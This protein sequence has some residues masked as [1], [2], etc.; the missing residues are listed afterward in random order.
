MDKILRV[1]EV[2]NFFPSGI[3][4]DYTEIKDIWINIDFIVSFEKASCGSLLVLTSKELY[5]KE[6]PTY[7]KT[8]IRDRMGVHCG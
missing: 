5:I 4:Y 6:D 3:D 8:Q 1:T 2:M 7:L